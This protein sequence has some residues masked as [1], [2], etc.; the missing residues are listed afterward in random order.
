MQW[1][2]LSVDAPAEFVEPLS[3]IFHRYGHGGVAMEEP[4]GFNPDEGEVPPDPNHVRITTYLPIDSTTKSRRGGIDVGVALVSHLCPIS[5]L[6]E[7]VVEEDW[8]QAWKRHF[9]VL[10]IGKRMVVVPTWREYVASESDI[11]IGLDPGM[12]FG[13]GHHPTTHM[14]MVLLEEFCTPEMRV[15]DVGCGSGILSILAAKL[16]VASVV[17]VEIDDVAARSAAANITDNSVDGIVTVYQGTLT[18]SLIPTDGFD[19]VVANVSG[20]VVSEL[21]IDMI[22]AL[23]PGGRIIASGILDARQESVRQALASAGAV[24]ERGVIDG[25]WVALVATKGA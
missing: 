8:E 18:E 5:P 7:R 17:G 22:S 20:K 11:V 14:C 12:A 25:D 9:H 3:H 10:H 19:L 21:A 6:K 4:G 2:E 23:R 15:L 13:T 1:L 24:I 16:G